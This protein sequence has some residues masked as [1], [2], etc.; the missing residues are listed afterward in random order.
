MG[1]PLPWP[2]GCQKES[3]HSPHHLQEGVLRNVC[4]H[5]LGFGNSGE[6]CLRSSGRK[7]G[8]SQDLGRVGA[9]V[10]FLWEGIQSRKFQGV[11][12]LCFPCLS[13]LFKHLP[14]PPPAT[15][16]HKLKYKMY[17]VSILVV[18][19]Q[20]LWSLFKLLKRMGVDFSRIRD[21]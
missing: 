14:P 11:R 16:T 6:R 18:F 7:L 13:T 21:T 12:A 20:T 15:H 2:Q 17:S 9:G 1:T 19:P 3:S 4:S 10:I 8:G 5:L